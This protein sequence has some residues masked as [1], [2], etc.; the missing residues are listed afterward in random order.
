MNVGYRRSTSV[1]DASERLDRERRPYAG[2]TDLLPLTKTGIA[3]PVELIDLKPSGLSTEIVDHGDRIVLGALVTLAQIERDA[4]ARQRLTA[5]VDAARQAATPQI[6]NRATIAGNLLQRPRCWYYRSPDVDCWLKGGGG[7]PARDGRNEHHAIFDDSPCVA[8]HPSDPAGAL[9]ALDASVVVHGA[10]GDRRVPL[11][12]LF[13]APDEARRSETVLAAD[14]VIT[15]IEI[16]A[17]AGTASSYRKAMDRA[18]W[19]FALAGVAVAADP[20]RPERARVVLTG[21][22]NTPRRAT[23]TE[24][25]LADGDWTEATIERAAAACLDG[26]TPLPGNAYKQRLVVALATDAIGDVA[27]RVAFGV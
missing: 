18:A 10:D 19:A 16:P 20:T 7:C 5:L 6:R 1:A 3:T 25:I 4:L 8:V 24:Q 21:V 14:D 22:A 11:D 13:A 26:A 2:G 15:A 9:L 27:E 17:D 23:T 12:E